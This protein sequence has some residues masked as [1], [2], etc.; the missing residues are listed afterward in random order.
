MNRRSDVPLFIPR[1]PP[2]A[3]RLTVAASGGGD[4]RA[5]LIGV[6]QYEPSRPVIDTFSL[7]VNPSTHLH[8]EKR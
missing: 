5:K 7:R 4:R 1:A 3:A 6:Y 2:F 8:Q